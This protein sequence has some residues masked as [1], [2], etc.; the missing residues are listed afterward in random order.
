MKVLIVGSQK[1][2]ALENT[3]KSHFIKMGYEAEIYPIHDFF[4]QY[5]S[6]SIVNKLL[7]KSGF[8]KIYSRL[9]SQFIEFVSERNFDVVWVFKGMEIL[10]QTLVKLKKLPLKLINFNPD[11]PF[12]FSG[13][14]SGNKNV[15]KGIRYYDLH[16]CYHTGVMNKIEK[17]FSI[18]C[19]YLPFG[20]DSVE[21]RI[22][23]ENE[24][25]IKACFIGNPD[26]KRVQVIRGLI[27]SGIPLDVY[28]ND[29]HKYINETQT[30][31]IFGP[32]YQNAF[33][34][35]A[36]LYRIHINIFR[37]HNL[38]SH[39]MRTFEIPGLGCIMAAPQSKEHLSFFEDEK[40]VFFYNSI[41][42]LKIILQN[43][44]NLPYQ[45]ALDYRRKAFKRCMESGYSYESRAREVISV[46]NGVVGSD[47]FS[48][49]QEKEWK[50]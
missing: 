33:R 41:G 50:P 26:R 2:W 9:N 25:I 13:A 23:K 8:G 5:Y 45:N 47:R 32:V 11:H 35:I 3:Y 30:T 17:E 28:G 36:P 7:H 37:E 44:L 34:K 38:G 1:V 15:A 43:L 49:K 40:E 22:P 27:E 14:G 42:Q 46:F 48:A 12:I 24:E 39:N 20:Y 31:K 10:P 18:P 29:W 21:I 16:L 6:Q 19:H 4:F